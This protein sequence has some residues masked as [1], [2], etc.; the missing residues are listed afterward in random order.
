M[1]GP[2]GVGAIKDMKDIENIEDTKELYQSDQSLIPRHG[3]DTSFA[4]AAA[5]A[6]VMPM[7]TESF[8]SDN[9]ALQ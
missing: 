9:P 6:L 3:N 1:L 2:H 7:L 8:P 4:A 5:A